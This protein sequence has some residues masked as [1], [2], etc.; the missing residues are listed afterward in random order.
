MQVDITATSGC[1]GRIIGQDHG[2]I[3]SPAYPGLYP[4][5]RDCY[6]MLAVSPGSKILFSLGHIAIEDGGA[7]C[8]KDYL[9]VCLEF[10]VGVIETG[11][12]QIL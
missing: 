12:D 6:W 4:N 10:L 9:Q 11:A 2:V 3:T 8:T 5:S 1:G 7:N